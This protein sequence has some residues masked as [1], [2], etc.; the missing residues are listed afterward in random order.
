MTRRRKAVFAA[1]AVMVSVTLTS[2]VVLAADLYVHHRAENSAGLNRWGYRGPVVPRKQAGEVR[3]VMVGGS[4]VFGYG[5]PW[6]EA[7]PAF[8]EQDLRQAR[9]GT[10]ITVVN[11]GYNN[12]GAFAALPTLEDYRYLDYDIV[13][14]YEGYNDRAGDVVSN[15]QV[16]RR[17]SIIF[18]MT[19]YSPI[20]PLVLKEKAML[21]R[22][23]GQPKGDATDGKAVFR[24]SLAAR[25]SA[26]ALESADA[27]GQ[28]LDRQLGGLAQAPAGPPI[29]GADC[30]PPWSRYCESVMRAAAYAR[31]LDAKVLVVAPPIYPDPRFETTEG[32]QHASVAAALQKRFGDDAGVR[33]LDLTR[34]IDLSDRNYSFDSMH[35]GRD[36]NLLLAQLMRTAVEQLA[37]P[38][39]P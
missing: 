24:P 35:L 3:I 13:I 31:S 7:A 26:T 2:A 10:P 30:A 34:A 11:L 14:L 29:Q 8:L 16:Y 6:H 1:A 37:W 15:T 39:A 5:G 19:G 17:Q 18:R 32:V 28:M 33:Y 27:V 38:G 23:G 9:P 4:T 20:L 21:L 22:T 25:A 36:G 12:E